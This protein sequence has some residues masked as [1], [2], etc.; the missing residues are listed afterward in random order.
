MES[1]IRAFAQHHGY[2]S[3]RK[4]IKWDGYSVYEPFFYGDDDYIGYSLFILVRNG[5]IRLATKQE[6]RQL[7]GNIKHC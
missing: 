4:S 1:K 5:I 6:A 3:I 7:C 2:D